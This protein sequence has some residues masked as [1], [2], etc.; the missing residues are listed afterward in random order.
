MVHPSHGELCCYGGG[1]RML[2]L[3]PLRQVVR[4]LLA[5]RLEIDKAS[6]AG[7]TSYLAAGTLELWHAVA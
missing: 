1:G 6:T 7:A 4:L 3:L 2:L 5:A